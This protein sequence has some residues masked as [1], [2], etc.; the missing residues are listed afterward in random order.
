MK[1]YTEQHEWVELDGDKATIGISIHAAQELGDITFVEL[2]ELD[3]EMDQG[4][5]LAV[6]KSVKAAADV[7]CPVSGTVVEVNEDL[8]ETPETVN[9]DA[10]GIGWICRLEGVSSNDLESLMT[11]DA[12]AS[13][14]N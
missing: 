13:F 14:C 3:D 1:R 10:E 8:E 5:Q 2:P 12:Y 11:E 6:V 7:Y 4:D 9:N